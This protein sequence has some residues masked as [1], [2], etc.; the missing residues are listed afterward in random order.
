MRWLGGS[1]TF[2]EDRGSGDL[3]QALDY[4]PKTP[5]REMTSQKGKPEARGLEGK[6]GIGG[7]A[8]SI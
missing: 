6:R 7:G 1:V 8:T 3:G 2:E 5:A 4:R